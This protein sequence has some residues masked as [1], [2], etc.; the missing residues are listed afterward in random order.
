MTANLRAFGHA[1]AETYKASADMQAEYARNG[2]HMLLFAPADEN[3]FYAK[4]PLNGVADLK[5]KRIRAIGM[6]VQALQAVGA[7]PVALS[8]T[9]VFEALNKGLLDATSG[10][11]L[12]LGVDF[13]FHT[14]APFLVDPNYGVYASGTYSIN[15]AKYD[16][17]APAVG[18]TLDGMADR[19]LD[20]YFFPQMRLALVDRCD[21]ARAAGATII[22]W[23]PAETQ[24]WRD[25]VGSAARDQWVQTASS[26]GVDA[27]A[28]LADYEARL[29]GFE[30]T[31]DWDGAGEACAA[32]AGG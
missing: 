1:F 21:K 11:T 15:K 6:G 26:T 5:D 2:L 25:A 7:N 9:E 30:A 28:F 29:R 18:E 12:D 13:G 8:Q 14:V 16:A 19:F 3:M 23:D 27:A 31:L 24:A 22:V 17:L 4:A 10:A 20:D 32:Q